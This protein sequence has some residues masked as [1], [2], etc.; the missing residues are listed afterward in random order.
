MLRVC[1][2]A[3]RAEERTGIDDFFEFGGNGRHFCGLQRLV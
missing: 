1:A 3:R 2:R